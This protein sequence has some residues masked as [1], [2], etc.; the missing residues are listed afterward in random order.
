MHAVE[1]FKTL[2]HIYI[3]MHDL[4]LFVMEYD[5]LFFY[6]IQRVGCVF[7]I[8]EPWRGGKEHTTNWINII[9]LRKS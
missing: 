9:Y 1:V 3:N 7:S 8:S 6:F 4:S 2:M 5:F